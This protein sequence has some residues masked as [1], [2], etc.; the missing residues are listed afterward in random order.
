MYIIYDIHIYDIYRYINIYHIYIYHIL[1]TYIYMSV[2]IY[3]YNI[4]I[5]FIK[6]YLKH[7][8]SHFEFY[9][10]VI[11]KTYYTCVCIY[12]LMWK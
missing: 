2:Y 5:S 11:S 4:Y 10:H 6:I 12:R 1:Y 7:K 8:A 3:I 9:L